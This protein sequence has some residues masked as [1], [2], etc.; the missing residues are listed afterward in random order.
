M[1][2][3]LTQTDCTF[4]SKNRYLLFKEFYTK[5]ELNHLNQNDTR[6]DVAKTDSKTKKLLVQKL[7][8]HLLAN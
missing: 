8:G 3:Q 2:Y 7:F 1:H 6:F 4:F 5:D